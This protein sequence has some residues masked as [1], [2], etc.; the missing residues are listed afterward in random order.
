[1]NRASSSLRDGVFWPRALAVAATCLLL[2]LASNSAWAQ[3]VALNPG[4]GPVG[5]E[6]P[7]GSACAGGE[8]YDDGSAENGY[9]G[10]PMAVSQFQGVQQFTPSVYPAGYDTVCLALVSLAG[11]NLDFEIQVHDDNGAGGSPGTL[12]GS[13]P[14]SAAG[15]PASLPCTFYEFDISSLMLNIPDGS[16]YIGVSWNPMLFPSRFICA[17]ETPATPLHPGFV[18]FNTG[19]GW[20]ATQS[21]ALFPGYRAKLI[22]AIEGVAGGVPDEARFRVSKDFNDGNTAEVE[23]TLSCNTGLPLEQTTTIAEGD[24]VNFVI[25]D[26]EQGTLDCDVTEVVPEGYSASYNDGSISDVNCSWEDL[27]GGQYTCDITNSLDEVEIEVTKV[28]IDENPQFN[29]QNVADATWSCTNVASGQNNGLLQFFGNPGEDSFFV[30][31]DWEFGS[32]CSIVEVGLNES[33]VEVDDSECDGLVVFPGEGASC[34]IFNT[35]LFEGIPTLSQYGLGVL[36]LL[37]L[38]VGFVA[39]RR[40]I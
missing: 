31:P 4:V 20:Q 19:S 1:M 7:V 3:G 26:F 21:P 29:A 10:N 36:A 13:L 9:S 25:G 2:V 34:T 32:T 15:I 16:V 14:V 18:N 33:G 39:F 11:A 5:P 6:V 8:I 23:V 28:W 30:F 40:L 38:G 12:L 35:R 24:P 37:M 17:D 27:Q 22:R